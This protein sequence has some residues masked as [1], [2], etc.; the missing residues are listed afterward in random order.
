MLLNGTY[1]TTWQPGAWI[2][3]N[4]GGA[5]NKVEGVQLQIFI[6]P[7]IFFYLCQWTV[8]KL[9]LKL[10]SPFNQAKKL[11]FS[12]LFGYLCCILTWYIND[13]Y[14]KR[15]ALVNFPKI[16]SVL[17]DF[18]TKSLVMSIKLSESVLS[19]WTCKT[20]RWF[21]LAWPVVTVK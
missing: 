12:N 15:S 10:V 19:L 9:A 8:S 11:V 4:R 18:E 3:W 20:I 13:K 1:K 21:N 6:T 17:S 7:Y 2:A 16:V 5:G 14:Q